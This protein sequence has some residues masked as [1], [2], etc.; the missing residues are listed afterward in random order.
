MPAI[1]WRR[2]RRGLTLLACLAPACVALAGCGR[3][4]ATGG[5]HLRHVVTIRQIAFDPAQLAAAPGDTIVWVNRDLVPHTVTARDQRWDSG[6]LLPDSSWRLIVP[7]GG[8]S[9]GY[10]CRLHT[11]MHGVIVLRRP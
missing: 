6:V 7:A 1:T 5:P 3:S 8:D 9:A 4:P 11:N 10:G 2:V